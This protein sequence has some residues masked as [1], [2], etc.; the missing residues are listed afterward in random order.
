MPRVIPK[1]LVSLGIYIPNDGKEIEMPVDGDKYEY[2]EDS[3]LE[4]NVLSFFGYESDMSLTYSEHNEGYFIEVRHKLVIEI[5]NDAK[6]RRLDECRVFGKVVGLSFPIAQIEGNVRI[7]DT[8]IS[9][10][11]TIPQMRFTFEW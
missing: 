11:G 3:F 7:T 9:M 10:A 5:P 8:E 6:A 1:G 2:T 4:I